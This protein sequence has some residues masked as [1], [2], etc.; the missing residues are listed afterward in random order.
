MAGV[1]R[2]DGA[3]QETANAVDDVGNKEAWL[4]QADAPPEEKPGPS[5]T[6]YAPGPSAAERE[7]AIKSG[8]LGSLRGKNGLESIF[9]N[10]K[11]ASDLNNQP[12]KGSPDNLG[13]LG[14]RGGGG[15]MGIGGIG[16]YGTGA[17]KRGYGDV[18]LG[19]G[20]GE[21]AINAGDSLSK[22]GL[23]KEVI[24]KV[25]E[26]HWPQVKYAYEKE[27]VKNP[28]LAGRVEVNFVIGPDGKVKKAEIV[29]SE[30]GTSKSAKAVHAGI[31]K[32]VKTWTFPAPKGGGNVEVTYP[33]VFK[34]SSS[35]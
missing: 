23:E 24:G 31:L 28:N 11:M 35:F 17:S 33:F 8:L 20:N 1:T 34:S 13:G 18:N 4:A 9:G 6:N 27:L 32:S 30:L 3:P 29:S 25:V 2:V 14:S 21:K 19:S 16:T 26:R 22:G 12:V 15:A 10:S 5:K 7:T